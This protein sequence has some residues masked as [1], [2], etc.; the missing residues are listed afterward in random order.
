MMLHLRTLGQSVKRGQVW[1]LGFSPVV[2]F[3]F[4]ESKLIIDTIQ[5][6]A[7][8]IFGASNISD[9]RGKLLFYCSGFYLF[10]SYGSLMEYPNGNWDSINVPLG[11]KWRDDQHGG[12]LYNQMSLIL[13]KSKNTYYVFT[14]GMSDLAF[15]DLDQGKDFRFDV[16]SYSVVDM[17]GNDGKGKIVS[18][19]NILVQN[20]R[21]SRCKMTAVQHANGRDW[22]LVKPHNEKHQFFIFRVT[23]DSIYGPFVQTLNLPDATE[24]SANGQ[25][26]FSPDGNW[27]AHTQYADRGV[28][29][30]R[31][32]R[33]TG[34]MEF[35]HF[36]PIIA[37]DT[38]QSNVSRGLNFSAN[39]QALYSCTYYE[40]YQAS[41]QDTT[42][43]LLSVFTPDSLQLTQSNAGY[44]TMQLAP[45][46]K[47][48]VG[49]ANGIQK[50]MTYID[51]PDNEGMACAVRF[52][53]LYQP[54][55]NIVTPPN[56]PYFGL[57]A[58][59]N[60]LCDTVGK[61][62]DQDVVV[63]PNPVGPNLHVYIPK[64]MNSTVQLALYNL[65]G[66]RVAVWK[67]VLDSKQEVKMSLPELATGIYTLDIICDSE[68][69]V[70]KLVVE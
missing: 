1:C 42:Q 5:V 27:Y 59:A 6:D 43:P 70:R 58:I 47:I 56:M 69:Y 62:N 31:F 13:P 16:L 63:Y 68:E 49:N 65:L 66:Q 32:D 18:K 14:T 22:W 55:T 40:I 48:Y 67:E 34:L 29:V 57:G 8:L 7:S 9:T 38:T 39:S 54:Y 60:S 30:N 35:Y 23:P 15:D 11:T 51:S 21:L 26:C 44:H 45:N 25:S 53:G 20:E 19:N 50:Y 46:N 17:D 10:E 61:L 41:I 37:S 24:P 4:Q 33:C 3:N 64:P 12:S 36:Y 52:H 2:T 28:Y